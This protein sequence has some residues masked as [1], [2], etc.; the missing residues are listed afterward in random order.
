MQFPVSILFIWP[1]VVVFPLFSNFQNKTKF[2]INLH[3]Q[4]YIY[5][6]IY[7]YIDTYIEIVF[8]LYFVKSGPLKSPLMEVGC[9]L[10]LSVGEDE[11]VFILPR[12]L[13]AGLRN[14]QWKPISTS[15]S[16]N[17]TDSV[18]RVFPLAV[19]VTEPPHKHP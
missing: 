16:L 5:I 8:P 1:R 10:Q 11:W 12:S 6:Y 19:G 3:T 4:I 13:T 7:I 14:P 2:Y 15:G 18:N 17:T 9:E